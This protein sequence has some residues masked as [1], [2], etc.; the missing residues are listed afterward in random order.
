[1]AS[2]VNP[3]GVVATPSME[4]I[5]PGLMVPVTPPRDF[6]EIDS[7]SPRQAASARPRGDLVLEEDDVS[8]RARTEES[9]RQRINRIQKE[10]E[11]RLNAVK[12]AYK[13]YF[14]MDDYSTELDLEDDGAMEEDIW[15]GEN[16]VQLGTISEHLWAD[17][18][19]DVLP[20]QSPE[21]WVKDLADETEVKRLVAM[22]VLV[23]AEEFNGEV[24]GRLTTKFVRDWRLKD[25]V[26][27]KGETVKRWMRRSRYVAREF[28][29]EKRLD[30]FSPATGAHTSNLIPLKYLWMKE[31]AKGLP[32]TAEYDTVL[33]C[34]D[35]KDAFL[36]VEP[37]EPILVHIQNQ[38]Y[39]IQKNLPGQR[40]GAKQ[41]FRHLRKYLSTKLNYSF[42]SE[43]PCLAR[44]EE[45]TI[46]I[47][48]DDIL[49]VGRKKYWQNTF[50]K[51]M[52]EKFTV[53]SSQLD[54][55]GSSFSFLRRKV[56]ETSDGLVM[57]PGTSVEKVV[58]AFEERF[59]VARSQKIPC[60]SEIQLEDN[61]PLLSPRDA[62]AFR[63]VVG[64]CLY[65]GRERPDLMFTIKELASSMASPTMTALQRLRKMIGYMKHV[66]DVGVKLF[67]PVPG[68]GKN[69]NGTN[70][71]WVL[72]RYSDA[73]WSSNKSHRRSTSCG[74]HFINNSFVY[75]S[76][77]TQETISLSS[78]ESELHSLVSCLCDGMFIV[79]CAEFILGE[80]VEH[81]QFTDS[82]SARQLASR[83]GCGKVRHLSGK[84][85]WI[86]ERVNDGF[87]LLTNP[88]GMELC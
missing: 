36:Q 59:G 54:G 50:L 41:R 13:E 35:V 39:V 4:P 87:V 32:D 56:T 78:C 81:I 74:I 10:Y 86:Q 49:F 24:T 25:C 45:S 80:K 64:L 47:H 55:I 26:N 77:R 7:G 2:I 75:G 19:I 84:I 31:M 63:S 1:M 23:P 14:T 85:L 67:T 22:G 27:E 70:Q 38:P 69:V 68:Q 11:S 72:E 34:L 40:M 44:N 21:K 66:G 62:S 5:D 20:T 61:S 37:E 71:P 42:C 30:T 46:I 12:I 57:T 76:S 18:P 48:V 16:E 52:G 73:D 33:G 58:R 29:S 8:K 43:Q 17:F 60:S 53:S 3:G 79:A 28:A 51:E 88:Y 9:K 65:I 6:L 15:A 82:S 83:Q